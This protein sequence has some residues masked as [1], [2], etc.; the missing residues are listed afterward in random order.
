[1]N[2]FDDLPNVAD[3]APAGGSFDDLP[4]VREP[5]AEPTP[6]DPSKQSWLDYATGVAQQAAAGTTAEWSDELAALMGS[7]FGLGS[8]VGLKD[9]S[10]I[11]KEQRKKSEDFKKTYPK[12]AFGAELAG[13]LGTGAGGA[14]FILNAPSWAGRALRAG[15]VA[16]PFG[17]ATE[18]G[19]LEGDDKSLADYAEAAGLGGLKSGL[20][21]AGMS[22][23]GSAV[24]STVGPWAS[25]AARR[26]MAHNI[27]LTI[28][29]TMGGY[30]KRIE[31]T[32]TSF[33]FIGAMIRNRQNESNEGFNLA[34]VRQ[35]L[36]PDRV[37]LRALPANVEPGHDAMQLAT[38]ILNRRYNTVV[39][40][41]R[42]QMDNQL[43]NE[44]N[45]IHS[46]LPQGVQADFVDAVRRHV[47]MVLDPVTNAIDGR[48][49]QHALGALRDEGRRLITSQASQAYQRDLGSALL[50]LRERLIEN[51]GR[52]TPARTIG[53]FRRIQEA[54][55]GFARIRE[56]S[57]SVA[58]HDGVFSAAQLHRAVK[59]GDRSAG[60]GDF[61]RGQALMQELSND[62]KGAMTRRVNDSGTPERAAIVAAIAAP[63]VAAQSAA[64]ALV[65]FLMYTRAGQA[66]MRRMAAGSPQTRAALRRIIEGAASGTAGGSGA[67]LSDLGF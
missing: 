13:A 3:A 25:D 31:D 49:M 12:T 46:A 20:V 36:S 8:S 64:P 57:G 47:D 5:P 7:G 35:A 28:G 45:V 63:S 66:V 55:A 23:A 4:T 6:I 59:S 15:A 43:I 48:G 16:A 39:P 58:A 11:L 44:T 29:E 38:G 32:M 41:L 54:Y 22:T 52:Y 21:G 17:A 19:K 24:G 14:R 51:A 53:D 26:L 61:A 33:P 50:E 30:A 67:A 2:S 34:A 9:R 56:A 37:A 18:T 40:R 42:G 10:E 1:M 62:A 65:P 27:P 60:K